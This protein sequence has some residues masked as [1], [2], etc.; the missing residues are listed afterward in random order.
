MLLKCVTEITAGVESTVAV[1]E[2]VLILLK[3]YI[4]NKKLKVDLQKQ[5]KMH[6]QK[7]LKVHLSHDFLFLL[8]C[9]GS[10]LL[11]VSLWFKKSD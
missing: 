6:L 3:Q 10:L 7:Q 1:P 2:H 8:K 9:V 11:V 5:L 4:N